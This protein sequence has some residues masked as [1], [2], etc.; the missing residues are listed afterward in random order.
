MHKKKYDFCSKINFGLEV[1]KKADRAIG[2]KASINLVRPILTFLYYL[3]M[4]PFRILV[5][6]RLLSL[7]SRLPCSSEGL[8]TSASRL[9]N[10]SVLYV[11]IQERVLLRK[12]AESWKLESSK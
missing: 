12:D 9:F 7:Q 11:L 4:I 10:D 1:K 6:P 3:K 8:E 5:L 2:E